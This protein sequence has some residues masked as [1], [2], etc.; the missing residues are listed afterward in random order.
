MLFSHSC[1]NRSKQHFVQYLL[2]TLF[3]CGCVKVK[4]SKYLLQLAKETRLSLFS[5]MKWTLCMA[6]EVKVKLHIE[7]RQNS[8]FKHKRQAWTMME[9]RFWSYKYTLGS[10]LCHWVNIWGTNLYS[11][12]RRPCLCSNAFVFKGFFWYWG[13]NPR[14]FL[15]RY[16][17]NPVIFLH[18]ERV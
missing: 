15:P 18:G 2:L 1:S 11:F 13:L 17:P 4:T 10:R 14:H 7:L 8:Y 3:L 5:L 12:A 16:A 9:I 6:Q